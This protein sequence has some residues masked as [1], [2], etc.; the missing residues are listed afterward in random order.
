VAPPRLPLTPPTSPRLI[1]SSPNLPALAGRPEDSPGSLG[2]DAFNTPKPSAAAHDLPH[3]HPRPSDRLECP[4]D[5]DLAKDARG[6]D[7]VFGSGAWSTVYR[8]LGRIPRHPILASPP[9][10]PSSTPTPVPLI[11]A[12]KTPSGRHAL[13]I[14]HNEGLVLGQITRLEDARRY[15]IPFYGFHSPTS[16]LILGAVPLSLSEHI[17]NCSRQ[18]RSNPESTSTWSTSPPII[19]S[20]KTWLAL[21]DQTVTGLAWLHDASAGPGIVHGAESGFGFAYTPLFADFSSSQLLS[22]SKVTPNTLSAVTREYTAPELLTSKVLGDPNTAATKASDVFSLAVT[23]LAAVTGELM[24]YPGNLWQRQAM[25]TQGWNVLD[26]VRNGDQGARLPRFGI[27]E[28]VL[29]RAVL[30]CGIGG[31]VEARAW[32][33]VVER[34][35]ME[36]GGPGMTPGETRP[37][38]LEKSEE[39]R[40]P[41]S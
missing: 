7:Q 19:G 11:V 24:V 32:V 30:R 1:K 5:F 25:A 29:E 2:Q 18:A 27:V 35:K 39:V 14:I 36:V 4:F 33:D 13:P 16:S 31:R 9:T 21:A 15:V 38:G 26:F 20:I 28:R 17:E 22:A 8:A 3:Q 34:I 23:L 6:R 40:D 12:V 10:P 41:Q 37:G